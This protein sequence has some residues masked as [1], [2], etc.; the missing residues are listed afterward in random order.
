MA[1][2]YLAGGIPR[3]I[4]GTTRAGMVDVWQCPEGISNYLFFKNTG[5][6]AIVL[7]FTKADADA[8]IGISIAN[9]ASWEGPAQLSAFY[10][11]A[12]AAQTFSSVAYI[13]RG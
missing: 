4:N 3:H 7:S 5:G 12:A 13:R 2:T 11:K 6:A 1:P 10:T 8:G 9:G